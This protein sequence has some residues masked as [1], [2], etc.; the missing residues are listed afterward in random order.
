MP[1][2]V[3]LVPAAAGP[4]D[5]L[6]AHGAP[7][8]QRPRPRPVA[9]EAPE[10]GLGHLPGPG[11]ARVPRQ[12]QQVPA[13]RR[14]WWRPRLWR[15]GRLRGRGQVHQLGQAGVAPGQRGR[16]QDACDPPGLDHAPAADQ[17]RAREGRRG[18]GP[19]TPRRR[20]RGHHRPDRRPRPGAHVQ[21]RGRRGRGGPDEQCGRGRPRAVQRRGPHPLGLRQARAHA[22]HR[23]QGAHAPNRHRRR[24]FVGQGGPAELPHGAQAATHGLQDRPHQPDVPADPRREELRLTQRRAI[25]RGRRAGLP[26]QGARHAR[27]RRGDRAEG[28]P[29]AQG[30]LAAGGRDQP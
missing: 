13:E 19:D 23:R 4:G 16:C 2:P 15:Q 6:A 12:R 29:A 25:R 3:R 17:G 30:V 14:L 21:R 27:R 9:R 18:R 8:Q 26:R 10:R 24:R 28:P 11:L 7:Q 1:E 20:S 22:R 5:A